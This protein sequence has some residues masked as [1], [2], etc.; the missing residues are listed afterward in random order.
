MRRRR[1]GEA[2]A[3]GAVRAL[4]R[5]SDP[6]GRVGVRRRPRLDEVVGLHDHA[7]VGGRGAIRASE[8]DRP[9]GGCNSLGKAGRGRRT[10]GTTSNPRAVRRK[11]TYPYGRADRRADRRG[12]NCRQRM[13][14]L[15]LWWVVE[16]PSAAVT[17]DAPQHHV[18][19]GRSAALHLLAKLVDLALL[20]LER[21]PL[22]LDRA[23]QQ[24]GVCCAQRLG[25]ARLRRGGGGG[26]S[27]C[28]AADGSV[29]S[30]AEIASQSCVSA[31][32]AWPAGSWLTELV[33]VFSASESVS[34][35]SVSA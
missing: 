14:E 12:G 2:P 35:P 13:S 28:V 8:I 26:R 4:A 34:P 6:E 23:H 31:S 15:L 11:T 10:A 30:A 16:R 33:Q 19:P 7:A 3:E 22:A 1:L 18:T 32:C 17:R 20:A 25:R 27:C 9:A 5:E 29:Y 24:S 21:V